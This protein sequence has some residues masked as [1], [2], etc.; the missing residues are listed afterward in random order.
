MIES[1]L[2]EVQLQIASKEARSYVGEEVE[3][4]LQRSKQSYIDQG[5]DEALAEKK[6]VRDMG[7]CMQLGRAM[8]KLHKPKIDW[9]LLGLVF[10]A[11][12]L[13]FVPL[14]LV[15]ETSLYIEKLIHIAIA[16]TIIISLYFFDYRVIWQGRW[17]IFVVVITGYLLFGIFARISVDDYSLVTIGSWMLTNEPFIALYVIAWAAVLS[18]K[19]GTIKYVIGF[20]IFTSLATFLETSVPVTVGYMLVTLVM[21]FASHHSVKEKLAVGVAA[22][23]SL[24]FIIYAQSAFFRARIETVLQPEHYSN[25]SGNMTLLIE[26]VRATAGM[27]GAKE[28]IVIP[29]NTSDF[30]LLNVLQH[31]GYSGII[32][33]GLV[34]GGLLLKLLWNARMIKQ[35]FGRLLVQGAALYYGCKLLFSLLALCGFTEFFNMYTPFLSFGF[36]NLFVNAVFIGLVLSVYHRKS[37]EERMKPRKVN[38][39]SEPVQVPEPKT[40]LGKFLHVFFGMEDEK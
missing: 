5:N 23:G 15:G 36:E 3:Q 40:R 2:R 26:E 28:P 27:Y 12:G 24:G 19:K 32:I 31:F 16:V 7:S 8:N 21:I 10:L 25:G 14:M 29:D 39:D 35:P 1:F 17:M 20:F 4:H 6:A 33:I 30:A 37:F 38:V 13:G 9:L 18:I 22:I 11:L 34:L